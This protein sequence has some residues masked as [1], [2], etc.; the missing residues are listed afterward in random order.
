MIEKN[1][2]K[3]RK[4]RSKFRGPFVVLS[5]I[6]VSSRRIRRSIGRI[7]GD[8]VP[9]R[10]PYVVPFPQKPTIIRFRIVIVCRASSRPL[11]GAASRDR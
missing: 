3:R 5:W 11:L 2:R 6:P 7:F 1:T 8:L 9:G 4:G 10:F